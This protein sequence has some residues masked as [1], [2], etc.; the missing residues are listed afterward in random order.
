MEERIH[1]Y[2]NMELNRF[3]KMEKPEIVYIPKLPMP[4]KRNGNKEINHSVNMWQRGYIRQ[5]LKQKCQEQSI[6]VVEVF[7][8]DISSEC[9]RCGVVG[10]RRN[11]KFVCRMC[12]Y[13]V[14]EKWNTAQNVLK[15]GVML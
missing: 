5:R 9:S 1:S 6:Q 15:R 4:Q 2:I 10:E 11:G 13:E 12:N 14:E 3:L 7:G 8:K